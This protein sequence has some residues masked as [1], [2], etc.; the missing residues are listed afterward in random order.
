TNFDPLLEMALANEHRRYNTFSITGE[1][2]IPAGRLLASQP[3]SVLKLHGSAHNI[4]MSDALD[5]PMSP[6]AIARFMNIFDEIGGGRPPLILVIGY[7]G[8]DRR[9]MSMLA[10]HNERV[11]RA[12]RNPALIWVS[13]T[14]MLPP[15]FANAARGS[16]AGDPV[17]LCHYADGRLFLQD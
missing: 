17:T 8:R 10:E 15:A 5:D 1:A 7:A 16:S 2:T 14:G 12:G 4:E 3:C 6:A 13:R 11:A 9:V